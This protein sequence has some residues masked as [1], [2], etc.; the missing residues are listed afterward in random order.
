M[1]FVLC[2][3]GHGDAIQ[4]AQ[5]TCGDGC[6][7]IGVGLTSVRGFVV[8]G[9]GVVAVAVVAVAAVVITAHL[10]AVLDMLASPQSTPGIA[11]LGVQGV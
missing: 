7:E 8:I 11:G 4:R 5:V 1:G 6:A 10:F 3:R 2:V 9:G